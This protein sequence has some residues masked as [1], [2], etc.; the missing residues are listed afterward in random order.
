MTNDGKNIPV[1]TL[2][3]LVTGTVRGIS[4]GSQNTVAFRTGSEATAITW[5]VYDQFKNQKATASA[6]YD[7]DTTIFTSASSLV[8]TMLAEGDTLEA[9]ITNGKAAVMILSNGT[10]SLLKPYTAPML[11]DA[12]QYTEAAFPEKGGTAFIDIDNDA[13]L[14]D[15]YAEQL[16]LYGNLDIDG[17]AAQIRNAAAMTKKKPGKLQPIPAPGTAYKVFRAPGVLSN[18]VKAKKDAVMEAGLY[19]TVFAE[20]MLHNEESGNR[21]NYTSKIPE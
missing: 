2:D 12:A 4:P 11:T 1:F 9:T 8:G 6:D 14:R 13:Q 3:E 19:N 20:S 7:A 21:P 10:G 17:G 15:L 5:R 16:A 18:A